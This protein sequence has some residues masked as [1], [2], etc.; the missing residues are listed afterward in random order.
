[1]NIIS[2]E[3]TLKQWLKNVCILIL[4]LA[5]SF[6]SLGVSASSAQGISGF[7]WQVQAMDSGDTG[8]THPAGL[9]FSSK[10]K[11]FQVIESQQTSRTETV[12]SQLTSYGKQVASARIAAVVQNPINMVFDDKANRLLILQRSTNQLLGVP[13]DGKTVIRYDVRRF[14]LQDPQGLTID[15]VSGVLYILDAAGP[16]IIR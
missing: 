6:S 11:S 16:Q 4:L 13:E 8:L 12:L 3:K 7:I 15:P 14:G 1:M 9:A 5:L 2:T 10:S